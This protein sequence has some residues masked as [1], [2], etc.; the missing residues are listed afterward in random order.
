M[1]CC[2]KCVVLYCFV[3]CRF[4]Q[5]DILLLYEGVIGSGMDIESWGNKQGVGIHRYFNNTWT[6][7]MD[8]VYVHV[9]RTSEI[10]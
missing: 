6:G 7:G 4:P 1:L 10:V 5:L 2:G 8:W 9:L 3:V